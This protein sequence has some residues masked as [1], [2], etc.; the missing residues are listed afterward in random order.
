[1]NGRYNIAVVDIYCDAKSVAKF[2]TPLINMVG[3]TQ[4]PS[5]LL[6]YQLNKISQH[7]MK[8]ICD[9]QLK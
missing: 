3:L 9:E 1:M 4:F 8:M 5:R 2:F 6:S 7:N